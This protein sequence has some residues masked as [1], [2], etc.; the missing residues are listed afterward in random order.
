MSK[1]NSTIGDCTSPR[2]VVIHLIEDRH[3]NHRGVIFEGGQA[4]LEFEV[5]T[6]KNGKLNRKNF[7]DPET[8]AQIAK[9]LDMLPSQKK[10]VR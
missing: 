8:M 7:S 5:E 10:K 2:S 3:G 9:A 6:R 4:K 1:Q